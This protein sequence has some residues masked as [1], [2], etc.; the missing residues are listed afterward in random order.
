MGQTRQVFTGHGLSTYSVS[1]PEQAS[2]VEIENEIPDGILSE[3]DADPGPAQEALR[4]EETGDS[5]REKPPA[6]YQPPAQRPPRQANAPPVKLRTERSVTSDVSL[7]IRV[8]L[9]FDR[10]GFC[11]FSLLPVRRPE[12]DNEVEV[13]SGRLSLLLVSQEDWYQDLQFEDIG[14]YLLAGLEL[15]GVLADRRRVRWL[16]TGR[17]IYVL[18]SH[19]RAS[20]FVSTNQLVLG[21][22]H[23]VMCLS[24]ML[25]QVEGILNEAGCQA[26]SKL[27]ETHGV[28]AGWEALCD[29]EPTKAITLD[30][31]VDPFYAIKPAPDMDIELEGGVC[32]RNSVWL[33]GY[34]PR[35]K[36]VPLIEDEYTDANF[37]LRV[38]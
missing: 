18:A 14:G 34:P 21:R 36:L 3:T 35:V 10:S 30:A 7:E 38:N 17:D 29:V 19:P 25:K 26:Y 31:G 27:D 1:Q 9:R 37:M 5:G 2:A 12:L 4:A 32:L 23:I 6:R 11:E 20:Y 13:K 24:G 16:L 15:K 8:R 28:P 22:T 33:A